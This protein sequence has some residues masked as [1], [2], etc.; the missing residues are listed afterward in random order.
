MEVTSHHRSLHALLPLKASIESP[1]GNFRGGSLGQGKGNISTL[2][3]E[4]D[5]P[6]KLKFVCRKMNWKAC[7]DMLLKRKIN[8]GALLQL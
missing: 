1:K 6:T 4:A 8:K 3:K 2:K 7:S 5:F